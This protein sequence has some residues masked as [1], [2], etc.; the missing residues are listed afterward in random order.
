M[1]DKE[2]LPKHNTHVPGLTQPH[3][4]IGIRQNTRVSVLITLLW[5]SI[6]LTLD[7]NKFVWGGTLL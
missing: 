3:G 2:G 5:G 4:K 7:I 6:E 1:E